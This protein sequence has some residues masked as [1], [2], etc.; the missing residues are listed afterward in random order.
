MI[1]NVKI[2][3][4]DFFGTF[5]TLSEIT[6]PEFDPVI[7]PI[8][9]RVMPNIIAQDI[10]GVSPMTGPISDIFTLRVKYKESL[11]DDKNDEDS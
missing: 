2:K 6:I 3:I 10:I 7:I 1:K 8:I 11:E 4:K 9:R 5:P